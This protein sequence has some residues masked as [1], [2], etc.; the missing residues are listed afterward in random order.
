MNW[1]FTGYVTET[2]YIELNSV[3]PVNHPNDDF[4]GTRHKSDV[5]EALISQIGECDK[6]S[7]QSICIE[8]LKRLKRVINYRIRHIEGGNYNHD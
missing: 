3:N 7:S 6:L 8:E 1:G 4:V 5:L 2:L